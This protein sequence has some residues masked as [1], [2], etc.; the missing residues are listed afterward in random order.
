[1]IESILVVTKR[2]PLEELIARFNSRDQA[3]FYIEHAGQSFDWYEA[4]ELTHR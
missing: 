4:P 1:V 3:K 2:T